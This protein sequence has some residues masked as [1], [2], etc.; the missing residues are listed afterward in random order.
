MMAMPL[1]QAFS[2]HIKLA[3][4][5]STSLS[6]TK[7]DYL[8][9]RSKPRKGRRQK[10]KPFTQKRSGPTA[11]KLLTDYAENRNDL[12]NEERL[13]SPIN[14]EHFG[15]CPG[16]VV[17]EKVGDVDV[18]KSAKLYFSSTA[19]RRRR[20]DA[21][22]KYKEQD[23]IMV[24]EGDDEFYQVV[25]PSPLKGWRTQAKLAV[26]PKSSTWGKDGC[27]FGLY[28]RGTHKVLTIPD[29]QVHHPSINRAVQAL[30]NATAKVGT[31]AYDQNSS[32]GGLRYVQLQLDRVTERVCLTLVW[33]AELL[34]QTQPAVSRLGKALRVIEPDL[35][36]SM[37]CHCND[38]VGNNIF[39]RN[40]NRWHRIS[41][42]E[43]VRDPIPVGDKGWLY[44]NPTAFR[45][46]NMDGFDILALDV[47]RAV[48]GGSKVCELY[49][50][51]GVLGLTS[52][53]Y[54]A[55]EGNTPLA[56]LR[57]SDENPA[58]PRCFK[59]AVDSL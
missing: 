25:V 54:H 39:S 59:R 32:D 29:C 38:G 40:P 50:G 33:N 7:K 17:N 5:F 37:W 13:L 28:A 23:D 44:F 12:V 35:W 52:L 16:C 46:G 56:W 55:Q 53:A 27:S 14:C 48:P 42:P 43:F 24:E 45:Q 1:S 3:R 19:V 11:R 8:P 34:K 58:N 21:N 4:T 41:G 31:A 49:A 47:A 57:C 2:P 22:M 30:V 51:V 18:I 26:A 36:H 15:T 10:P 6:S 9:R 20:M